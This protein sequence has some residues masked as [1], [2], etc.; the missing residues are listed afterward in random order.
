MSGNDDIHFCKESRVRKKES[1]KP[2]N[3]C[4]TKHW[5]VFAH[6]SQKKGA[7]CCKKEFVFAKLNRLFSTIKCEWLWFF[8]LIGKQVWIIA[9]QRIAIVVKIVVKKKYSTF[10]NIFFYLFWSPL[11]LKLRDGDRPAYK[12]AF[13]LTFK[14]KSGKSTDA[15]CSSISSENWWCEQSQLTPHL[16]GYKTEIA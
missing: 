12:L 6:P 10:L 2:K 8:F 15:L 3:K 11:I 9:K 5:G 13:G 1:E 14:Q 4:V 16:R 7:Q